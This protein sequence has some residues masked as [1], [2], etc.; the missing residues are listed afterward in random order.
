MIHTT[1]EDL[2]QRVG[3]KYSLVILVA[4]RARQLREGAPKLVQTTSTNPITIALQ[5][6]TEGKLAADHSAVLASEE[7]AAR[8]AAEAERRAPAI[9]IMVDARE[10]EEVPVDE[11]EFEE[12]HE[13]EVFDDL[14]VETGE[15]DEVEEAQTEEPEETEIEDDKFDDLE[16]EEIVE[17]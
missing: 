16:S 5:E 9:P 11:E 4:K 6:I 13:E 14:L 12:E 2:E 1:T 8:I 7:E 10:L 17:E 15:E 3:G